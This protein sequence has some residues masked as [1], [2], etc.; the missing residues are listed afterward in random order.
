[1]ALKPNSTVSRALSVGLAAM[2]SIPN[3]VLGL[4]AIIGLASWLKLIKVLPD[5]DE[6]SSWMIVGLVLAVMPLASLARVTHA[7][8]LNIL[9]E[10]YIRA[11]RARGLTQTRVMLVHV[12]RNAFAPILT[13]LGPTVIEMF[14][15]LFIV[16][17]LYAFPGLGREYWVS[18]LALDYPMILGLTLIYSTGIVLVNVLIETIC[19]ALDPRIRASTARSTV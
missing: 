4:L 17:N 5:W 11:A 14:A 8:V 19:E 16:E 10:E 3:F 9:N 15:G 7:S 2:I 6:P 12:M 18:V 13:F 1:M